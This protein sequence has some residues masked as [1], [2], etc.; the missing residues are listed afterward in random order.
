MNNKIFALSMMAALG[1]SAA[2]FAQTK[3]ADN[4]RRYLKKLQYSEVYTI[5]ISRDARERST[6]PKVK[7]FAS[8]LLMDHQA[9]LEALNKIAIDRGGNA[10]TLSAKQK[11]RLDVFLK[12]EPAKLTS[13][14]LTQIVRRLD[15]SIKYMN[16]L[17]RGSNDAIL[18]SYAA[19]RLPILRAQRERAQK[20]LN[21]QRPSIQ[22]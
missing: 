21:A 19:G 6:D 2:G 10:K 14:Y 16:N 17:T 4:D 13:E 8:D 12:T 22:G 3:K 18:K 15:N 7:R 1:F 11:G 20:L 5:E 9:T